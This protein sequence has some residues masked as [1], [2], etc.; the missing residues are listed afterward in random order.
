MTKYVLVLLSF[1]VLFKIDILSQNIKYNAKDSL[2]LKIFYNLNNHE[3][4]LTFYN[5]SE[6][7]TSILWNDAYPYLYFFEQALQ[8]NLFVSKN[9]K[10]KLLKINVNEPTFDGNILKIQLKSKEKITKKISLNEIISKEE[11]S[12]FEYLYLEYICIERPAHEIKL[13]DILFLNKIKFE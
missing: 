3:I 5:N 10:L 9:N 12:E 4:L 1:C 11:L 6:N 8:I 7:S 13:S 2:E